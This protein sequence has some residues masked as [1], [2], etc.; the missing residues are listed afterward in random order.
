MLYNQDAGGGTALD[1]DRGWPHASRSS[2]FD[3]AGGLQ[4][5]GCCIR[6]GG[7]EFVGRESCESQVLPCVFVVRTED[8]SRE[9]R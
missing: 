5:A 4:D 1:D 8:S 7:I 2:L 3:T 6:V 9:Q